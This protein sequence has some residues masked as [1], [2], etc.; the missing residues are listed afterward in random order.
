MRAK[1]KWGR[2]EGGRGGKGLVRARKRAKEGGGK[3]RQKEGSEHANVAGGVG[4]SSCQ[5]CVR[6]GPD[7]ADACAADGG[8]STG[9]T[10]VCA[11]LPNSGSCGTSR[12][13]PSAWLPMFRWVHTVV[14]S[15]VPR[16][17]TRKSGRCELQVPTDEVVKARYKAG[18][19]AELG[20][21]RYVL[22]RTAAC[23]IRSK[24]S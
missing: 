3:R 22:D 23:R 15:R 19:K 2:A 7:R 12:S 4:V 5:S 14:L 9:S 1:G 10:S 24:R 21:S 16:L 8:S 20:I 18:S 17:L 13:G 11:R 6:F